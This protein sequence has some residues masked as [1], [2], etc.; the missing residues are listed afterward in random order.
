MKPSLRRAVDIRTILRMSVTVRLDD[1]EYLHALIAGCMRRAA[2]REK[3][4]KNY[5]G[6]RSADNEAAD[7]IGAVG[8]AC[9]AKWLDAWWVG[10]G[11]FRGG[12]VRAF[13]VRATTYETGHL[14]LN[15]ADSD[16]TPYICVITNDGIGR[17]CGWVYGKEGKQDRYL[18]DKSGRGPA[19]YVPQAD[20]R[21]PETL[22]R[23]E[24]W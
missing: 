10:A 9:V 15:A 7:L 20:L 12:D 17:I 16:E 11:K 23:D 13:Q 6:A 18:T 8:E 3:G 21:P 19:F 2:A 24:K 1:S 4:R 22:P 14:V 5:Y